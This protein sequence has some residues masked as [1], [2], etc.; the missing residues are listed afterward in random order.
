MK[1]LALFAILSAL[2]FATTFGRPAA[3]TNNAP[4]DM[5]TCEFCTFTVN[6]VEGWIAENAT[7]EQIISNL[8]VVC[9]LAPNDFQADCKSFVRTEVPIIIQYLKNKQNP[10]T[11]CRELGYCTSFKNA[12]KKMIRLT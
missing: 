6:L 4:T 9:S 10:Q 1:V 8:I 5:I 2:C 7:Q 12:L 3:T 11:V